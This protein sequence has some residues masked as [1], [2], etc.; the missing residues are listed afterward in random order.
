MTGSG[1][2]GATTP[3]QAIMAGPDCGAV[4]LPADCQGTTTAFPQRL[5]VDRMRVQEYT[6]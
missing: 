1:T 5:E 6:G 3:V 2:N 4:P